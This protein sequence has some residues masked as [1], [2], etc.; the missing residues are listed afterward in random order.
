VTRTVRAEWDAEARVWVAESDDVPGLVTEAETIERLI[1]RLQ[2]LVPELLELNGAADGTAAIE[3]VARLPGRE[4][5]RLNGGL[6]AK[7]ARAAQAGGL[8]VR[9]ARQRRSRDLVQS[10]HRSPLPGQSQDQITAYGERCLEAGGPA[11]GILTMCI[12]GRP[13]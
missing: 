2:V 1:E 7:A 10:R 5:C 3:L 11:Q 9:S 8:Q 13:S 6:R 4:P 12:Q